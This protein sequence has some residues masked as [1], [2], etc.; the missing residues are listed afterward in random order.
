MSSFMNR[1]ARI[2]A[3]LPQVAPPV[4]LVYANGERRSMGFMDAFLEVAR[5]SSDI[6]RVEGDNTNLLNAMIPCDVDFQDPNW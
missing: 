3:A 6:I 1:I 2:R 5:G 4:V